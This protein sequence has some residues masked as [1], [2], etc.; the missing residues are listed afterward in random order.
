MTKRPA[1]ESFGRGRFHETSHLE[2]VAADS[3]PDLPQRV[4]CLREAVVVGVGVVSYQLAVVLEL[5]PG[6]LPRVEVAVLAV[7]APGRDVDDLGALR[8]VP[9]ELQVVLLRPGPTPQ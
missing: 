3:H 6:D 5:D 1:R 7:L 4:V 8:V 9:D 2:R